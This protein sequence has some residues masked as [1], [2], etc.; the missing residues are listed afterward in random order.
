MF[1]CVLN[2]LCVYVPVFLTLTYEL[3]NFSETKYV[4]MHSGSTT[5]TAVY[6]Q[7]NMTDK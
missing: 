4:R 1:V 5:N 6:Q 3:T 2:D 7:R